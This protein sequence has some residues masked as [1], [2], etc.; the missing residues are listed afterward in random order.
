[1]TIQN[2]LQLLKN[3]LHEIYQN[4][5]KQAW[6]DDK[7]KVKLYFACLIDDLQKD[8]NDFTREL[9]EEEQRKRKA[10]YIQ[11]GKDIKIEITGAQ[12]DIVSALTP[13]EVVNRLTGQSI[14]KVEDTIE[15]N[16]E[17]KNEEEDN[18]IR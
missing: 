8:L 13:V 17:N 10:I 12:Y 9:T 4:N 1:M 5:I 16:E 11:I 2:D 7:I 14:A 18:N 6:H 15:N 3:Y